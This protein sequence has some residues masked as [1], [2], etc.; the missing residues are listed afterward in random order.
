MFTFKNCKEAFAKLGEYLYD[1]HIK[2][3]DGHDYTGAPIYMAF[4]RPVAFTI[5][6]VSECEDMLYELSCNG[7]L[8]PVDYEPEKAFPG[9][10]NKAVKHF[11]ECKGLTRTYW[12]I[13]KVFTFLK[14]GN[15]VHLSINYDEL[16]FELSSYTNNIFVKN[17]NLLKIFAM[18]TELEIGSITFMCPAGVSVYGSEKNLEF[19]GKAIDMYFKGDEENAE[20]EQ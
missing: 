2:V 14:E 1:N 20:T 18:K 10:F 17:Y 13:D 8:M 19:V 12:N 3:E 7:Q 15:K 11:K 5:T 4:T 9:K 16:D 6:D